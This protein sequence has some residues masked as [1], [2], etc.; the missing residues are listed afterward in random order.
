MQ[1]LRADHQGLDIITPEFLCIYHHYL[2]MRRLH[3]L[4]FSGWWFWLWSA[5]VIFAFSLIFRGSLFTSWAL[6]GLLLF[7]VVSEVLL[8]CIRGT[9]GP[10]RF[11]PDPLAT[12]EPEQ[13]PVPA[14]E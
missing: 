11:G 5:V 10:N 12:G 7:L 14:S 4:N 13:A 2:F 9:V 1:F 3:D 8:M 6:S